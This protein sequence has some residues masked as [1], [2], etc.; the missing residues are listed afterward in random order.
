MEDILLPCLNKE[1]L[2]VDCFG[3]GIQR[4]LV[5]LFRGEFVKAF[6]MYPAIY[7]LLLLL[8]FLIVNIFYKF[9]NDILIRNI[10]IAINL[11]I[12]IIAYFY[13]LKLF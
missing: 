11:L 13:K 4:S 12:I 3:C 6:E 10:L 5:L 1:L 7:T 8:L 9:K 2:G